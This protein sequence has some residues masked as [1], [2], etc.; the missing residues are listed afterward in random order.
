VVESNASIVEPLINLLQSLHI[1]VQYEAIELIRLLMDYSVKEAL[2]KY[3]V[4]VLKLPK[5]QE[6]S[7]TIEGNKKNEL[8]SKL[9][10]N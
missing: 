4:N 1:E 3:L 10:L 2:I 5:R 7:E 8:H 9:I 6:T